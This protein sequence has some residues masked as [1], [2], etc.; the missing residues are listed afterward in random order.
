MQGSTGALDRISKGVPSPRIGDRLTPE[1]MAGLTVPT[2]DCCVAGLLDPNV[3]DL[4]RVNQ[5][6]KL[7]WQLCG[8]RVAQIMAV[9]GGVP[10]LHFLGVS[11][12]DGSYQGG[13]VAPWDFHSRFLAD[14]W[15][16][17]GGVVFTASQVKDYWNERLADGQKKVEWRSRAHEAE[18]LKYC[19]AKE[20]LRPND[21]QKKVIDEFP[22]FPAEAD[23][24]SLPWELERAKTKFHAFSG[25]E[26]VEPIVRDKL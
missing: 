12:K 4:P 22:A 14:P 2:W 6:A 15:M 21:Y 1:Q 20:G 24:A 9:E 13:I 19:V 3:F 25:S 5:L 16:H 11:K 17:L 23:Y 26:I 7:L 10:T 18:F 8:S